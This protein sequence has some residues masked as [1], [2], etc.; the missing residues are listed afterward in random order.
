MMSF[1]VHTSIKNF[2]FPYV[3][4][5]ANK[6]K[7]T[8]LGTQERDSCWGFQCA[9]C[10]VLGKT[11]DHHLPTWCG[12]DWHTHTVCDW[13]HPSTSSRPE[14]MM[15]CPAHLARRAHT[16]ATGLMTCHVKTSLT[17]LFLLEVYTSLWVACGWACCAVTWDSSWPYNTAGSFCVLLVE[18]TQWLPAVPTCRPGGVWR[19][20]VVYRWC[21]GDCNTALYI[22]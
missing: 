10:L 2:Q 11:L 13:R 8:A 15:H 18:V 14:A 17:N 3:C 20:H 4:L 5:V 6:L 9:K 1:I 21:N 12:G 19:V 7:Q 22:V 16:K